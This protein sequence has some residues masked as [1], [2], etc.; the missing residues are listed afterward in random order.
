MARQMQ[1]FQDRKN[2]QAL[3]GCSSSSEDSE[4]TSNYSGEDFL[5]FPKSSHSTRNRKVGRSSRP[6]LLDS[7]RRSFGKNS[8]ANNAVPAMCSSHASSVGSDD[9]DSHYSWANADEI[10]AHTGLFNKKSIS[11]LLKDSAKTSC[12]ESEPAIFSSQQHDSTI[13]SRLQPE[14][15]SPRPKPKMR[16]ER[17]KTFALG[18]RQASLKDRLSKMNRE[19]QSIDVESELWDNFEEN[20]ARDDA[21]LKS[22]ATDCFTV[23]TAGW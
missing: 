3:R 2:H 23:L 19:E 17:R 18:E 9:L 1:L 13:C 6:S 12:H 20:A 14:Q 10:N 21:S 8:T 22:G 16:M 4:H 11:K 5:P 15:T 7:L